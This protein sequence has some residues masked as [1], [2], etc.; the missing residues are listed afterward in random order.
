LTEG[1]WLTSTEPDRMLAHLRG[2]V[3]DRKVR[4]FALACC[5]RIWHLLEERSRTAVQV[6]EEC[7]DGLAGPANLDA[8]M[9]GAEAVEGFTTGKARAAARAVSAA[10]HTAEHACSAA[11]QAT[12]DPAAERRHQADLLREV[13][14]NPFRTAGPVPPGWLRWQDGV[15]VKLAQSFYDESRFDDISVLADA[16]EEAGCTDAEILDH[17]RKP[18]VHARGCWPLDLLLGQS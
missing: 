14:G 9:A 17:C 8:A 3:S 5:R 15:L 7:I 6:M 11:A 10:W 1:D 4:L 2:R 13:V 18:G 12:E 16:L